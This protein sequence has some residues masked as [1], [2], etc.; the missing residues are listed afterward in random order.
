MLL[1][2]NRRW[3]FLGTSKFLI[4]P[5]GLG[6]LWLSWD[7]LFFGSPISEKGVFVNISGV[8]QFVRDTARIQGDRKSLENPLYLFKWLFISTLIGIGTGTGIIIFYETIGWFTH[9]GLGMVVGY[10]PPEAT[11]EGSSRVMS[12]WSAARPWMLPIVTTL[13]GLMAGLMVWR[14]A[15]EAEGHGT[16]ATITAFHEGDALRLRTP[17]VK[18]VTSALLIGTGGSTGPEGP[19]GQIGAGFGS[20]IARLLGLDQEDQRIALTSGIGAGIGAIFRAPLGGAVLAAE[21][22]YR[23]DV[24]VEALIPA[25]IS[26]IVSY[27]IFGVWSGWNP[28][29]VLTGTQ[30]FS[31]PIQ[32]IY[33]GALGVLCGAT[34]LFFAR[35]MHQLEAFFQR[36][37]MPR[38]LKPACG[39]LVVGLM[40][41]ALP[42]ILGMGYGWIQVEM[43]L[44]LF[45]LPIWILLLLPFIKTWAT[46][47]SVGSGGPGGL[48]GPGMV[49]GGMLG[50]LI[51]RISYHVLPGL[52][53][54]SAPFVIIGMMALFGSISHAP[55]AMM[56]MV[57]EMTG[58]LSL[59]A[60]A[61]IAVG[62]AYMVVGRH[63]MYPSQ[64]DTRADSP[65]HRLHL[66]FP[67]LA[68]L[69]AHQAMK[70]LKWSLR[71]DQTLDEATCVLEEHEARGGPILD[72]QGNFVGVLTMTDIQRVNPGERAQ[73]NVGEVMTKHALVCSP[74]RPLDEVLEAMTMQRISWVPVVEGDD[75]ACGQ[76][77]IGL[78]TIPNIM[79]TYRDTKVRST[80]HIS[81]EV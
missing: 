69:V 49:V 71:M 9:W 8:I 32:L 75:L 50:A 2:A 70:P 47:F 20:A 5:F 62:V 21:I 61:M 1:R 23:S 54:T 14:L 73:Q 60:P 68:T 4:V 24:E 31:S 55:L 33:Y 52:P 41:L 64:P 48:F 76:Q 45:S 12:L 53:T 18:L 11:G 77:V 16:D 59:L 36:L 22:L 37:E 58:N 57:A 15:P 74:E 80:K 7:D 28:I 25:L 26:S 30:G 56:L 81:D 39:G 46:G 66:S 40:G 72:D 27:S 42:Q 51:W 17:L 67:L 38:W 44:G 35:S 13:G 65:A 29:F 63:T 78:L 34:G 6:R 79:Q 19:A 43:G 3:V 10:F